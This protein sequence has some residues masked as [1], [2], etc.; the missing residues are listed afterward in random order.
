MILIIVIVV[1]IIIQQLIFR[2]VA[3]LVHCFQVELEFRMLSRFLF[4]PLFLSVHSSRF[5]VFTIIVSHNQ[6]NSWFSF[7]VGNGQYRELQ[8]SVFRQVSFNASEGNCDS[9]A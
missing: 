7:C 3:L 9:G 6:R 4:P 8:Q 1:I 5:D 2:E